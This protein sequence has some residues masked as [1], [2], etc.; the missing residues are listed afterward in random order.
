MP[1][2]EQKKSSS[3]KTRQEFRFWFMSL[4]FR[5]LETAISMGTGIISTDT[6]KCIVFFLFLSFPP[7]YSTLALGLLQG[8]RASEGLVHRAAVQFRG[9]ALSW[10][11]MVQPQLSVC[12]QFLDSMKV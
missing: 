4:L 6:H 7:F 2:R 1:A 3:E 9:L 10:G 11:R 8:F 5:F 12:S